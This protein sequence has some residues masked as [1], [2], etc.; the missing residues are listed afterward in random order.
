MNL[1][2]PLVIPLILLWAGAAAAQSTGSDSAQTVRLTQE[3]IATLQATATEAKADEAAGLA[4]GAGLDRQI[5]GEVG[6]MIGTGGARGIYGTAA[7]PIG[8]NGGAVISFENSRYGRR[9]Y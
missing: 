2:P 5:H 8:E 1:R 3:Q 4:P 9:G 6:A 7:I